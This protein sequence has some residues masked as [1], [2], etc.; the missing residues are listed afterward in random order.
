MKE[1]TIGD[2]LITIESL[3]LQFG[4]KIIL[5][6]VNLAINN[7]IRQGMQQGQC[8]ALLGPSG[9]GKTQLFRCIAGMQKP[10]TGIVRIDKETT[11]VKSGIVGV[12]QQTYP[13]LAHRTVM[14]NLKLVSK[15]TQRINA[16]LTNFGLEAEGDKY[17]I[18]LSGGQRQ[19]IAIIQQ[20]LKS[21]HFLLMD[22]PFSGLDVV[23]K[24]KVCKLINEVNTLDELNTTIFTSHDIDSAVAIADTVWIMGRENG[25]QGAT[26]VK[27]IDLISQGLAW[28]ENVQ[29]HPSFAP[30]VKELKELF[31]SL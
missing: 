26:I 24:D 21:N 8:V 28:E 11:P 20:L 10:T 25:K 4:E 5:R 15:N 19:R 18:Q 2:R 9:I 27:Q 13:L 30:T 31:K 17:P 3:S 1:Y 22:E 16:L 6:D 14:G 23:A 29:D 7:I 12:V